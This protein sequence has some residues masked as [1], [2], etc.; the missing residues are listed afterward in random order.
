MESFS[1]EPIGKLK[2]SDVTLAAHMRWDDHINKTFCKPTGTLA[3][4]RSLGGINIKLQIYHALL[5]PISITVSLY[6]TKT[7]Y[8]LHRILVLKQKKRKKTL[9]KTYISTTIPSCYIKNI[10][11]LA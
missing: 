3:Q 7:K 4:C 5:I 1:I 10:I 9:Q 11:F 8:N 2:T 6:E